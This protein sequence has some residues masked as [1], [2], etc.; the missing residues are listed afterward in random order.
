MK[1]FAGPTKG[2]DNRVLQ[3]RAYIGNE[4]REGGETL[5]VGCML[6]CVVHVCAAPTHQAGWHVCILDI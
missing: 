2:S 6:A 3:G 4:R 5:P 1:G